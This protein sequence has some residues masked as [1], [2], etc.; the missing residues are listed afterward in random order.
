MAGQG[1]DLT[2]RSPEQPCGRGYSAACDVDFSAFSL[3][4][5]ASFEFQPSLRLPVG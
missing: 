2:H 4:R 1:V 3:A 5:F